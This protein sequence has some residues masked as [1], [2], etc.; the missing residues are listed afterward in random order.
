[1]TFVVYSGTERYPL[2]SESSDFRAPVSDERV[3]EVET[4]ALLH[5]LAAEQCVGLERPV[6]HQAQIEARAQRAALDAATVEVEPRRRCAEEGAFS[7]ASIS[8]AD[9]ANDL[10]S[11]SDRPRHCLSNTAP[12][13]RERTSVVRTILPIGRRPN[14]VRGFACFSVPD[15]RL[16]EF[17]LPACHSLRHAIR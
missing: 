7:A 16:K 8:S 2:A 12:A 3:A 4:H 11:A 1:M 6:A 13:F 14:N 17:R 9:G 10:F 5:R 15:Y